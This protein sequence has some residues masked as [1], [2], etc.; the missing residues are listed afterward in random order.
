MKKRTM[1]EL[2]AVLAGLGAQPLLAQQP[3]QNRMSFFVTSAGSGNGANLGGLEGAD[4]HCAM[5]ADAVNV[6]G[7]TWRA[8]LSLPA[9]EGKAAINAKDRIGRGPWYNA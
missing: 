1:V 6:R 4:K 2:V 8:Y 5:L 9:A 7:A 3:Q